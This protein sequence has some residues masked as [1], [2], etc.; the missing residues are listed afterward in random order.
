M[1][2]YVPQD[3]LQAVS[4]VLAGEKVS[5]QITEKKFSLIVEG[6]E[7]AEVVQIKAQLLETE[8]PAI[9]E[10]APDITMRAFR[11]PSGKKFL[12]TDV[13][14]NFVRFATPPPGWQR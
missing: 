11:L 8:M 2:I 5:F 1:E 6:R 13:N 4:D 10:E 12:L 3:H 14:G 9:L 7:L